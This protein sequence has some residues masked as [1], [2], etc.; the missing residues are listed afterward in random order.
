MLTLPKPIINKVEKQS[1]RFYKILKN[2]L[3][4]KDDNILIISDYGKGDFNLPSILGYGYYHAAQS[5]KLKAELLFQDVKKGFM[6]AEE[7]IAKAIQKLEKNNVIILTVSDKL[8]KFGSKSFRTFCKDRGHRFI[9]ATGLGGVK[10]NHFDFFMDAMSTNYS[11][12]KKKGLVIKKLW[13]KADEIKVKTE[14]GT[15]IIFDVSGKESIA[16]VGEYHEPGQGGNMPAG[17][18]YIPPNGFSGVNGKFVID[19]SVKTLRK[20]FLPDAPLT[21]HVKEGRVVKLEGKHA[22]LLEKTFD[23]YENRA[24][25]PDRIKQVAELGIGINPGAV[26]IGSMVMDEKVLGTGHIAMGSNYWFGGDIKTIYH[27]DQV[28]KKP[29]F[30]VDGVK[31]RV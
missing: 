8:G 14:M 12:L 6:H 9:S 5:K 25:Y 15:D 18:V 16:N 20:T 7:H 17:E 27:G 1:S 31:M 24:K 10:S 2:S 11:R 4:I 3:K 26:L 23:I 13:D 28:F 21:I 19:G 29:V 30:Y 22:K